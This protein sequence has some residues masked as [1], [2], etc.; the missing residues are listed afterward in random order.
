MGR[1]R[2][3]SDRS[4]AETNNKNYLPPKNGSYFMSKRKRQTDT[5]ITSFRLHKAPKPPTAIDRGEEEE[6]EDVIFTEA[7]EEEEEFDLGA[8][9]REQETHT[10]AFSSVEIPTRAGGRA[11]TRTT[12]KRK[13]PAKR[14]KTTKRGASL[15]STL[16]KKLRARRTALK[17][18]L[19]TTERDI[20]SLSGRSRKKS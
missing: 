9:F 16:L 10:E 4:S 7:V 20:R 5:E 18:E 15:K 8:G 2:A 19:R 17:K 14:R 6:G 1:L 13:T 3:Q 12:R 11:K